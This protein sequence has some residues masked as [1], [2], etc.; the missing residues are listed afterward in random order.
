[1][2]AS[3]TAPPTN[4]FRSP[5]ATPARSLAARLLDRLRAWAEHREARRAAADLGAL[6]DRALKDIGI[7]RSEIGSVTRPAPDDT[8][9]IARGAL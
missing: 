6:S 9:R 3:L 4:C 5:P 8:R 2:P 7:D 1:M